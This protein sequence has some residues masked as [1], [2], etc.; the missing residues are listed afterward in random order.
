[1]QLFKKRLTIRLA[2]TK[3]EG[4]ASNVINV[5][6][7]GNGAE[8][9]ILLR[10]RGKSVA[11]RGTWVS[12]AVS[13]MASGLASKLSSWLQLPVKRRLSVKNDEENTQSVK[14]QRLGR[15]NEVARRN[16]TPTNLRAVTLV[17]NAILQKEARRKDHGMGWF[18]NLP[19]ELLHTVFQYLDNETL[20]LFSSLSKQLN[21][22]V[23]WYFLSKP[24]LVQLLNIP[25]K[26]KGYFK[27]KKNPF[28]FSNAGKLVALIIQLH[29]IFNYRV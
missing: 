11:E 29:I 16:T 9:S 17:Q 5:T 7:G 14:K 28:L 25:Q 3:Q 21:S 2:I 24:G 18:V 6:S 27:C 15:A 8:S 1:M 20:Q 10:G 22:N 4:F 13:E 26:D 19:T 23:I 12:S